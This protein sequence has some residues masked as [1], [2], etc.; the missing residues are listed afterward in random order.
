LAIQGKVWVYESWNHYSLDLT[1][2]HHKLAA[3]YIHMKHF[4]VSL[5]T[6]KYY[7]VFM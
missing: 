4:T 1:T 5:L 6:Q 3:C 7:T 2:V